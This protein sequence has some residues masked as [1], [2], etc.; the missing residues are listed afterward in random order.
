MGNI[1]LRG[2]HGLTLLV[3]TTTIRSVLFSFPFYCQGNRQRVITFTQV[4]KIS[5]SQCP[6]SNLG[7]LVSVSE[8]ITTT[9]CCNNLM[10]LSAKASIYPHFVFMVIA[11]EFCFTPNWI[12]D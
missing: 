3:L 4:H 5:K 7:S 10:F 11:H 9:Y 12:Y 6:D 8:L 2:L 1:I